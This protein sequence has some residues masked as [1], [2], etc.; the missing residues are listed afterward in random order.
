MRSCWQWRWRSERSDSQPLGGKDGRCVAAD[1]SSLHSGFPGPPADPW[2]FSPP[3]HLHTEQAG[4]TG[5]SASLARLGGPAL[6]KQ[7]RGKLGLGP[8]LLSCSNSLTKDGEG[9]TER[10]CLDKSLNEYAQSQFECSY[11]F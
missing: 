6:S 10:S 1:V 7:R 3:R 4:A 11:S 8:D 9:S 5:T 2:N